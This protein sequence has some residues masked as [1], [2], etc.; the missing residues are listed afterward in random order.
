VICLLQP[1]SDL[2]MNSL[3]AR[4]KAI[5]TCGPKSL[6]HKV[7]LRNW[8]DPSRG[9]VG[10]D[11]LCPSARVRNVLRAMP[12]WRIFL[13]CAAS[14]TAVSIFEQLYRSALEEDRLTGELIDL[15]NSISG[16]PVLLSKQRKFE[17]MLLINLDQLLVKVEGAVQ[18]VRALR[19]N[20]CGSI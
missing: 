15:S 2:Q 10:P 12:V 18:Q 19:C 3:R 7:T 17:C 13:L 6:V 14:Q 4:M 16:L 11:I 9:C 20:R 1:V 5:V 8:G